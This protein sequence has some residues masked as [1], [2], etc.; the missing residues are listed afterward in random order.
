MRAKMLAL[1]AVAALSLGGFVGPTP[2]PNTAGSSPSAHTIYG[3]GGP[4]DGLWESALAGDYRL[5]CFHE[6]FDAASMPNAT[7]FG[8]SLDPAWA[9]SGWTAT[10]INTPTSALVRSHGGS[11]LVVF[12]GTGASD[13]VNAIHNGLGRLTATA[14]TVVSFGH[15]FKIRQML[16]GDGDGY[17]NNLENRF[18]AKIGLSADAGDW[19]SA[20]AIGYAIDDAQLMVN[21][22]GALETAWTT[23][24]ILFHVSQAGILS[25]NVSDGTTITKRTVDVSAGMNATPTLRNFVVG[26]IFN[27]GATAGEGTLQASYKQ[28][29]AAQASGYPSTIS[30]GDIGIPWL[31]LGAPLT[32][33]I[34]PDLDP[35]P[36]TTAYHFHAEVNSNATPLGPTMFVDWIGACDVKESAHTAP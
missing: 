33:D 16:L 11:L 3:T 27:Q 13:S 25:V 34:F 14:A 29:G 31:P 26:F 36:P 30:Q 4:M 35:A 6:D 5:S 18:V 10:G 17:Y 9:T 19:N 1:L 12:A 15:I 7:A 2:G 22:T 20:V 28:Y 24:G 8:G 21:T 32:G 23:D